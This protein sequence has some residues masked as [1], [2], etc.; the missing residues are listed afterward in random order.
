MNHADL[1][2]DRRGVAALD[3]EGR[4]GRGLERGG[5]GTR[6]GL[7]PAAATGLLAVHAVRGVTLL[8][9]TIQSK[10]SQFNTCDAI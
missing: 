2:C 4:P 3:G 6:G 9:T 1:K 5:R 10:Q 8:T 7:T